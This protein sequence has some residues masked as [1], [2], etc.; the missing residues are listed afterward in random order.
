MSLSGFRTIYSVYSFSRALFKTVKDNKFDRYKN[1]NV[2]L[3]VQKYG[4]EQYLKIR[5]TCFCVGFR[6][7]V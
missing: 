6:L 5:N 4:S 3:K 2:T 7:A 1:D